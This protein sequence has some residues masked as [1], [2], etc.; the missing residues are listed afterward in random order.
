MLGWVASPKRFVFVKS[1]F[2]VCSWLMVKMLFKSRDK[3]CCSLVVIISM[4]Q[5]S[6]ASNVKSDFVFGVIT[7]TFMHGPVTVLLHN[8][9]KGF[10]CFLS[11]LWPDIYELRVT[12][13]EC[14]TVCDLLCIRPIV[15]EPQA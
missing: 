8:D 9:F 2:H 1:A 12:Q 14:D 5:W 7:H 10:H 15:S 13:W 4:V 3:S 11:I 6:F